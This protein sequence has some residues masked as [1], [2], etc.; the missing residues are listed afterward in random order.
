MAIDH[1]CGEPPKVGS[2]MRVNIGC[3]ANSRSA[4]T[5]TAAVKTIRI[6]SDGTAGASVRWAESMRCS[7]KMHGQGLTPAHRAYNTGSDNA[8]PNTLKCATCRENLQWI[9]ALSGLERW[10]P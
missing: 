8:D 9:W 10:A 1:T 2:T 6:S 5:K 7:R 3:T 4:L